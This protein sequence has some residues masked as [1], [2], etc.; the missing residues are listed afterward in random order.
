LLYGG[1]PVVITVDG[2][3]VTHQLTVNRTGSGTITSSPA[4]IDCGSLCSAAFAETDAVTL[5]ATPADGWSF[6]GWSGACSGG[7]V[8]CSL[9]LTES[10]TVNAI[11]SDTGPNYLDRL[12]TGTSFTC[13]VTD[14][15]QAKCWGW[16]FDGQLGDGTGGKRLTPVDVIGLGEDISTIAAG[17]SHSCALDAIGGV[18]CWGNNSDRQLGI[19]SV[20]RAVSPQNV[21]DLP[22]GVA[23][24]SLGGTHSCALMREGGV[25]CWGD[26]AY[27]KL[28]FNTFLQDIVS[29][30]SVPNLETG[31]KAIAA[32][33]EHSCALRNSGAVWCWGRNLGGA[34]GNGS[35]TGES[36][37]GPVVGLN[38][39]VIS[40]SAGGGHSCAVHK[41]G[42][43]MCWGANTFGELGDGT[44]THRSTPVYVES[45]NADFKTVAT[46]SSHTCGLTV[47][48][49]VWCWGSNGDGQ[50]GD[51]TTISR[52]T[53]VAVTG[54][55]SGAIDISLG[56]AH[57][58][59][60]MTSGGIK[61]WGSNSSGQLGNGTEDTD[62]LIP[63]DV[64]GFP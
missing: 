21:P 7:G 47:S 55:N 11:F 28:G 6:S 18:A 46:G 63:T 16:G 33:S 2:Q 5:T 43:V 64:I 52:T 54:L 41:F 19:P 56:S 40:I 61:C 27:M 58:C 23:S 4:G 60:L 24:I 38:S 3:A 42:N 48:G 1:D 9:T 22:S 37:P 15:G 26:G 25:K 62:S 17:G 35:P 13:A 10:S 50:L 53:P 14:S 44:T 59:A 39:G 32:G 36:E 31:V 45:L 12:A 34:L 20:S 57:S 51:G 30:A 29:P 8:T 49:G